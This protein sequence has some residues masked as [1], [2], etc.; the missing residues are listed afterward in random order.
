MSVTIATPVPAAG[1]RAAETAFSE[2]VHTLR[3]LKALPKD[4]R[5]AIMQAQASAAAPLYQR[6][7]ALPPAERELTA[8]SVLDDYDP[9]RDP[10][11]VPVAR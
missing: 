5:E 4:Q 8:F 3:E 6:D 2:R 7:L 10:N 9:V 1:P 11:E